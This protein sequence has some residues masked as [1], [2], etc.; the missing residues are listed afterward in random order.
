MGIVLVV[1]TV[2]GHVK[3]ATFD[4]DSPG[5]SPKG[6]IA[7]MTGKGQPRWKSG[8]PVIVRRRCMHPV[9]CGAG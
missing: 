8:V 9:N 1:A 2:A 3:S 5:A 6:W 7:T 4:N